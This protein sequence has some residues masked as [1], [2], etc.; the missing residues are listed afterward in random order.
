[1]RQII[2]KTERSSWSGKW[3]IDNYREKLLT[4]LNR[5]H[6]KRFPELDLHNTS[7]RYRDIGRRYKDEVGT[8]LRR[9]V[10]S[11]RAITL[12]D[13]QSEARFQPKPIV[14]YF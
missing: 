14:E 10:M 3:K 12:N 4:H 1:M 5:I 9:W 11:K 7:T 13:I 2:Q 8:D 6:M